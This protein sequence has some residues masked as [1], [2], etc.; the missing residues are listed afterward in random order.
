MEYAMQQSLLASLR[1]ADHER[2]GF[3]GEHLLTFGAG[4]ALLRSAARRRSL[5][6]KLLSLALGGALIWRA[7]SG[8]EGL[9]KLL[10]TGSVRTRR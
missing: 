3:P 1:K 7:A 8:R 5:P 2:I 10:P 6:G 4:T 9:R